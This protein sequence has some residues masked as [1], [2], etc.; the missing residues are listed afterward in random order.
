MVV[1]AGWAELAE[2]RMDR[3]RPGY[4]AGLVAEGGR[5]LRELPGS[6]SRSVVVHGDFN[7]GNVLSDAP[8]WLAIDP[9]PMNDDPGTGAAMM[10]EVRVLAD[11]WGETCGNAP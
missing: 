10:D 6:A 9:K 7:P 8:R 1:A 2:E 4:D 5:A 3:L 11:L